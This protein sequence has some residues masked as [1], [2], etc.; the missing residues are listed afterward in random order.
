[1]A[2]CIR[3]LG[4]QDGSVLAHVEY[5]GYDLE[6]HLGGY[7]TADSEDGPVVVIELFDGKL[8]VLVWDNINNEDPKIIDLAGAKE[9]N[10]KLDPR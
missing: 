7:S 3:D 4:E 1:M 8:R 2:C 9:E 5:T 6:I 10:Y